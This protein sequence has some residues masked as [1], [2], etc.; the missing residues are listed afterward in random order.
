MK[1]SI[2]LMF[3]IAFACNMVQIQ[4]FMH[5]ISFF[6]Y[7]KRTILFIFFSKSTFLKKYFMNTFRVSSRL[8]P[9]KAR[10]FVRPDLD[11]KL[12]AKFINR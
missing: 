4:S 3:I 9:D 1:I 5:L 12:F 11:P 7:Q 10:Y 6:S 2:L 8:G